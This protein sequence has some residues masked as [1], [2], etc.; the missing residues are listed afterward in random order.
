MQAFDLSSSVT[1]MYSKC[2]IFERLIHLIQAVQLQV[3]RAAEADTP[4]VRWDE[5][6]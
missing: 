4:G 6:L 5:A 1:N 3:T 2:G